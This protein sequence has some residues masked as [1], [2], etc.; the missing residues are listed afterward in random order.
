[1]Y[2]WPLCTG[3]P[4]VQVVLVCRWSLYAGGPC[5]QVVLVCRWPLCTG[6]PC[7]Q[8]ALVYRWPL[9]AGG[10]CVQVVLVCRSSLYAGRLREGVLSI[11]VSV[12]VILVTLLFNFTKLAFKNSLCIFDLSAFLL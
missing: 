9:Y 11:A 12:L 8:V 1:M 4:C 3:V 5:V 2:R 6:G 10:P 7:M